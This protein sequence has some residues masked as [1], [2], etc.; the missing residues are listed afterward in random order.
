[1]KGAWKVSSNIIG[2]RKVYQVYRMRDANEI[3]HSGNRE[4]S[5]GYLTEQYEAKKLAE[6]LNQKEGQL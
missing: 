2:D 5:G 4:Y 6:T 1:M 3:D